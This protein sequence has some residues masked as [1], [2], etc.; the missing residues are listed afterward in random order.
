MLSLSE[1][2]KLQ[3]ARR[4]LADHRKAVKAA[5]PPRTYAKPAVKAP[6]V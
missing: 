6:K 1:R 5:R 3:D 4:T 2:Q